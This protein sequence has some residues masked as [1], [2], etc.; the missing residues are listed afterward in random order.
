MGHFQKWAIAGW[1][2]R[3]WLVVELQFKN[4]VLMERHLQ[5]LA[6]HIDRALLEAMNKRVEWVLVSGLG[7]LFRM[8][9]ASVISR[10]LLQIGLWRQKAKGQPPRMAKGEAI[11]CRDAGHFDALLASISQKATK[12]NS[13][14][15]A[16]ARANC[17]SIAIPCE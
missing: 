17:H 10:Q 11:K 13:A 14:F 5:L 1:G 2:W 6:F 7:W 9:Q 3:W 8:S 15:S 12:P 4:V 16:L